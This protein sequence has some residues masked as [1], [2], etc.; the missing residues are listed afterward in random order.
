VGRRVAAELL[1]GRGLAV[2]DVSVCLTVCLTGSQGGRGMGRR[3]AAEL[4]FGCGSAVGDVSVCLTVCPT[5]GQGGRGVGRRVAAE[6]LFG[7]GPAVG[8]VSVCLSDCVP[9]G[10]S[11]REGR[12][13]TY[14]YG[15]SIWM[16]PGRG[17]RVTTRS[18]ERC[19]RRWGTAFSRWIEGVEARALCFSGFDWEHTS[20]LL[21]LPHA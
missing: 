3:V 16:R 6:L 1:F 10:W 4:L 19:W 9:D 11:G 2:G 21:F 5:G 12:G 7:C 18:L 15:A 8:D 14:R 13:S 20:H 17:R